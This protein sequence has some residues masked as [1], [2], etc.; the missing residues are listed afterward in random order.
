MHTQLWS[1]APPPDEAASLP[2]KI[3]QMLM[4]SDPLNLSKFA[5]VSLSGNHSLLQVTL[6]QRY[7]G[8]C[9]PRIFFSEAKGI[10]GCHDSDG[11]P[12]AV[13]GYVP[14]IVKAV[15]VVVYIYTVYVYTYIYTMRFFLH[16]MMLIAKVCRFL[17][18]DLYLLILQAI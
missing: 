11:L 6:T 4:L 8:E 17:G 3:D 7:L 13:L 9:H 12:P 18:K 10:Q 1:I 15:V 16:I 2:W 5:E 14:P